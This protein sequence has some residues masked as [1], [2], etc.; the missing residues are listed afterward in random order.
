MVLIVLIAVF[1]AV[2]IFGIAV[3]VLSLRKTSGGAI[4]TER[5][6]YNRLIN[7]YQKSS[8]SPAPMSAASLPR[9]MSYFW[10][11]SLGY[12]PLH[13]KSLH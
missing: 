12:S 11:P 2:N 1:L 4:E 10:I 8:F 3:S 5:L 9:E 6:K 7:Q 13:G